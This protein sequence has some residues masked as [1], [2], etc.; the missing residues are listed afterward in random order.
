MTYIIG[1]CLMLSLHH[2]TRQD[3]SVL[4]C[5]VGRC[6]SSTM[7]CVYCMDTIIGREKRSF[8]YKSVKEKC[9]RNASHH[10]DCLIESRRPSGQPPQRRP[11][12]LTST[13]DEQ[14]V[15]GYGRVNRK[16]CALFRRKPTVVNYI[17]PNAS[18][19]MRC[20]GERDSASNCS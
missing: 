20:S 11:G 13:P 3:K 7:R 4:S 18:W 10:K 19:L 9:Q 12:G 6:K 8:F 14:L 16:K 2:P 17:S 5:R 15:L 1:E